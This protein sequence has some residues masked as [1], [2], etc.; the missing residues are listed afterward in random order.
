M[1]YSFTAQIETEFDEISSGEKDWKIM[2]GDFYEP[3]HHSIEEAMGADGKFSG[4][5]ILGTDEKTGRTVLV[6]M[7][8]FGPVVQIGTPEELGEDEKPR[9]ANLPAGT[10]MQEIDFSTAVKGFSLPK[11]LGIHDEK[12]ISIGSGRY[13]P[14]VKYGEAFVSIPRGEDPLSVDMDRALEIIAEKE[15]AD[16]PIATIDGIG[17]TKG[18]GRF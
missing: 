15:K 18:K 14:Y 1:Q 17:V 10:N 7:S 9:Y 8:R 5:R 11:S 16:A 6:R 2:L 3:F 13:G 12:E 4:E